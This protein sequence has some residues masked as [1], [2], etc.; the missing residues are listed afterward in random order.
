M[1]ELTSRLR[2]RGLDVQGAPMTVPEMAQAL[3][4][5]YRERG[6]SGNAS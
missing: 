1:A 3:I 5:R 2:A 6:A 4:A